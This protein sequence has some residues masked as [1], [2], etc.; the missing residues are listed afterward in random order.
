MTSASDAPSTIAL[1]GNPNAGK[2]TLFNALTG[3]NQRVGNYAGVTVEVKSG[4]AFTPHGRKLRV[5]DLPGCYSL[6]ANSPDEKVALDALNGRLPGEVKP[7]L[8]VCVLDASNLER[9]L[10]LALQV[11]ELRLPCVIA[12][13]MV[14]VAERNG[15]RLDPAKLSE[16]LGVPVVSMQASARKGIVE[17]K[18]A[19]RLPHPIAAEP[20]WITPADDPEPARRA[21][22]ARLCELA[23]RRPDA[24]QQTRSDKFDSVLL[25]PVFGWIALVGIFFSLF[26]AI[27]SFAEIPMGWIE[28]AQGAL[29]DWI[30][31]RMAEGD[32]RS[33]VV[34][35]II[36]GV[37]GVLMFLPQILLLFLF[38]GL[39][40]SSGYMARAA[41]L[42]DGVMARAGLSG[43]SFLPLFSSF[44]CAIPGVMATRTI[45]S[46][47]ERLV[48]I[49]VAPWMSC[50][51]RLPVYFLI[52]PL[53]LHEKEGSWKQALVLFSIYALGT[54]TAFVIA[55]LLRG[56]LG[57]DISPGHF[58]L[59]LP[60]YRK[61]QWNYIF[62]HV[63]D[64]AFSF[65]KKAGTLILGLSILLWA[66]STYPKSDGADEA[67]ALAHSAMGR[68]GAVIEPVVRPLGFDGRM[69][70]AILTSF[71]AREV[72]VS[73][74]AI[75][76]RVEEGESEEETRGV[77]RD[78]LAASRWPDGRPIFT[79]LSLVS[80]LVF[81][82]YA[83]QC[84][85]TSA[86][87]AR[88]SGSW[89]WAA[90]QFLFMS[91]FAYCASLVVFQ[92]GRILGY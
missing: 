62:R 16:E 14:D 44:A 49:F 75:L 41:Y 69:G 61:P 5:L 84:L 2:T 72:F 18:Q 92:T 4:E 1:I 52:I 57:E 7:D 48:T 90:G 43:K 89:K 77:L 91:G 3:A 29:S 79:P 70:T 24:Y 63:L 38:I 74:M 26:W 55:R 19:L 25:H 67:E 37:G 86:V 20:A 82:I 87:V 21:F 42:M 54:L 13:N 27:F 39:L 51:A 45:D 56:K 81:F 11:I 64:R 85:P 80:L 28:S 15:L 30:E 22:I 46:A 88:E 33:L 47:K 78:Q 71:A 32:L 60:P 50:S 8:V 34:D 73:S 10:Q 36:G 23:A 65:V 83:L 59:E 68:I 9:H 53:L 17:L 35:G 12:L 31:S 58:L 40:E 66:L 76:Y 6:R